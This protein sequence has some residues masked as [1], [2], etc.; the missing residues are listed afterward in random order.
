MRANLVAESTSRVSALHRLHVRK[1][2]FSYLVVLV[3][4]FL[5]SIDSTLQR[6]VIDCQ[7]ETSAIGRACHAV[8]ARPVAP[9]HGPLPNSP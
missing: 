7:L 1:R 6:P 5:G 8:L 3:A 9:T 4:L 2:L